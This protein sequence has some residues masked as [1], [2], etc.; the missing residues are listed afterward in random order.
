[1]AAIYIYPPV[2]LCLN[3]RYGMTNTYTAVGAEV[4]FDTFAAWMGV[5]HAL[6]VLAEQG[7]VGLQESS[8]HDVRVGNGD[9]E[10]DV[11]VDLVSKGE[12]IYAVYPWSYLWIIAWLALRDVSADRSASDDGYLGVGK[13]RTLLQTEDDSACRVLHLCKCRRDDHGCCLPSSLLVCL[14]LFVSRL[15]VVS[16]VLMQFVSVMWTGKKMLWVRERRREEACLSYMFTFTLSR[17][18]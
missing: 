15:L 8:I 1:M 3:A 4:D 2:S 5:V 16:E 9:H 17:Q 18:A 7:L 11:L 12:A 10:V 14:F 13:V 6:F